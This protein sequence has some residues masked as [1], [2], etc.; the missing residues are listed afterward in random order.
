MRQ[1]DAQFFKTFDDEAHD[2]SFARVGKRR[3]SKG[4][5]AV[6]VKQGVAIA[7]APFWNPR[8]YKVMVADAGHSAGTVRVI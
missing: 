7:A 4:A 8:S 6:Q 1:L 5:L 2:R 3:R